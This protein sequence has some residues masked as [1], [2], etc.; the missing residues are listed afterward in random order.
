MKK[1][2][3][4]A[5]ILASGV[6]TRYQG[7]IPKQFV[8]IAG[9]TI[10]EHTLD[11]FEKSPYIDEIIVVITPHYR[12]RAKEILLNNK[13]KK[14]IKLLNGGATRKESSHIGLCAIH[15]KE[16][17]VIIHDCARPFV[18]Q[19]ILKD[20]VL[21]LN[22][23]EAVDVAIP[24]TDTI[25]QM[26][27]DFIQAIPQ[28][29]LFRQGQTPQCFKLSL[30][31]KAH[32]LARQDANFTD[33][34][35][36]IKKYKL[37]PVYVVEGEREN[38]KI[39]YP[40]DIFLADKIFQTR[41]LPPTHTQLPG[42]SNLAGK[43][44]VIIGGTSGIGKAIAQLARRYGSTVF[45]TSK[46][47]GVDVTSYTAVKRFLHQV[48]SQ[49]NQIDYVVNSA[50]VLKMGKL[51]NRNIT[52]IKQEININYIGN[53][54]VAKAAIPYLRK[55]QG[56]LLFFTSSSYTRGRALYAPYSSAKA[57]VVNLAQA[58]A[59]ELAPENIYVNIINPQRTATPMRFKAFGKEPAN[60]LL[61]AKQVA[62]ITLNVLQTD[63]TGQVIDVRNKA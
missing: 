9:K 1:L 31:K 32:E 59:E 52:D 12:Q 25:I 41:S 34:C 60:S 6:G 20:C 43:T 50:G 10:L 49:T 26:E 28:R 16:A 19:R 18:S 54:N 62:K 30:I 57:A 4:Y 36:L 5:I 15:D 7:D 44:L 29:S 2:T 14:V 33:D 37:S 23:Y 48:Y 8:K 55:S 22:K 24:A 42:K 17:H 63:I 11:V 61:S 58:L 45:V 27:G 51:E 40:S 13:Y 46:H 47:L 35:G 56:H 39:T 38:M 53:I 3:L 21:A